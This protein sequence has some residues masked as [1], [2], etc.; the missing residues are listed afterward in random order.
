MISNIRWTALAL[1]TL[2]LCPLSAAAIGTVTHGDVTFGYTNDFNTTRG[3][4]VDT[5]FTGAA[6]G[7]LT[8]ES[9]WFF[10]VSGDSRETAFGTPDAEDYS[11]RGGSV[12][13]LDWTDPGGAGL[14]S[15]ALAFEVRDTG[16]DSGLLFQNM[17]VQNTVLAPLTIDIFHFSDLD[18]SATFG[19]DSASVIANPDGIEIS[20]TDGTNFAPLMG[21]GADAYEITAY[22]RVLRD[23][24]DNNGDNLDNSGDGFGP[25]DFTAAFQWSVTLG[26]GESASFLTQ[27][28]S[29]TP[30][31]DPS[32]SPVPEPS[33][34]FL[35]ALGLLGLASV[36]RQ[37]G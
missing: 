28:G 13:R 11:L 29:N 1:A 22:N 26:I 19:G 14:F 6:A 36:G 20:V 2:I 37:R 23:L 33:T 31:A 17:T 10:R 32:T 34:A 15:A 3:D 30:L 4:T 9:W 12:G 35:F 16:V 7:D 21:Y 5:Q 27:F 8:W 24:T 25:G 18:L